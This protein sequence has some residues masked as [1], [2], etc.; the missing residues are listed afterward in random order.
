MRE[1]VHI[2]AGQC[3]N[4]IG[5]KV[6]PSTVFEERVVILV[7]NLSDDLMS[8]KLAFGMKLLSPSHASGVDSNCQMQLGGCVRMRL[9]LQIM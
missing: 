3:G 6:R 7:V 4:Q 2:Q 5:A 9:W 1:I 8:Y